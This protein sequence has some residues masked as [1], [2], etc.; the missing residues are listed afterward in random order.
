[1]NEKYLWDRSGGD[2]EIEKLE[3]LLATYKF[4]GGEAPELPATN[5]IQMARETPR[6]RFGWIFAAS[7]GLALLIL[8]G[9]WL[10]GG[11]S[12][13]NVATVIEK[14]ADEVSSPGAA[15]VPPT[16]SEERPEIRTSVP[17]V[18]VS[19]PRKTTISRA[20]YSTPNR[21]RPK[22]VDPALTA[23]EKYAYGQLMLALS[24]TGSKLRVV[25]DTIDG[26][27]RPNPKAINSDK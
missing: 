19:A 3:D 23:E 9:V 11:E 12:R 5:V 13:P 10:R 20:S 15:V 27:E 8:A 24:I 21:V 18:P 17:A 4:A 6:W 22:A 2:A 1:M 14:G 26:V 25:R 16:D 7:A